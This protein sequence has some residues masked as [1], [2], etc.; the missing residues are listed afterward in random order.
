MVSHPDDAKF[1]Q[2]KNAAR[3]RR[4]LR[5][6]ATSCNSNQWAERDSNPAENNEQN[7]GLPV[8][9]RTGAAGVD[10]GRNPRR[11]SGFDLVSE[12]PW[13]EGRTMFGSLPTCARQCQHGSPARVVESRGLGKHQ[14]ATF[15]AGHQSSDGSEGLHHDGVARSM[16]E[17]GPSLPPFATP[18][19]LKNSCHS[20]GCTAQ[21][22]TVLRWAPGEHRHDLLGNTT[23]M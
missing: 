13:S 23:Y 9:W 12:V 4:S 8:S 17:T 19:R 18:P 21:R 10:I 5:D 14:P 15:A 11:A 7:G 6:R 16:P 2:S 20:G 3:S 1:S 22:R